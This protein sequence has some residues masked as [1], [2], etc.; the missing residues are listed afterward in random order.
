MNNNNLYTTAIRIQAYL[1]IPPFYKNQ[2]NIRQLFKTITRH[3][4]IHYIQR[5]FW[6]Q[7]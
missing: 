5:H 7:V 2:L 3:F 6:V 4:A 1:C